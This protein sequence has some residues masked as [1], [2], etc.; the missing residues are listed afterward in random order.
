M[1]YLL[2]SL[3]NSKAFE[4]IW[5]SDTANFSL[6]WLATIGIVTGT[7]LVTLLI[8]CVILF[9]PVYLLWNYVAL[10]IFN[11]PAI[12]M[13]QSFGLLLLVRLVLRGTQLTVSF[14]KD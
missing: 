14:N 7:E 2:D 8:D 9:I 10:D 5:Y 3:K 13:L 4:R 6:A 12:T 1:G 11:L